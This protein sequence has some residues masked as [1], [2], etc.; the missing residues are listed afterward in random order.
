M[1]TNSGH[2]NNGHSDNQTHTHNI[3][4]KVNKT[5]AT[6]TTTTTLPTTIKTTTTTTAEQQRPTITLAHM[7]QQPNQSMD[8]TSGSTSSSSG[9]TLH[10]TR[11]KKTYALVDSGSDI[12]QI[13][14]SMAKAFRM[15]NTDNIAVPIVYL[16]EEP[17]ITSIEVLLG[18]GSLNSTRSVFNQPVYELSASDFRMPNVTVN[19]LNSIMPTTTI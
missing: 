4:T 1:L 18:I 11:I 13:T 17:I 5:L 8:T 9:C 15:K 3:K 2:Q 16:Y 19:M 6:T 10:R 14:N 12:T 7:Q